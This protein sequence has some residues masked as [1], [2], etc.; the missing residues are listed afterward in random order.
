M[1]IRI[2]DQ[3]RIR[4]APEIRAGFDDNLAY[5]AVSPNKRDFS[6]MTAD[7]LF[8]FGLEYKRLKGKYMNPNAEMKTLIRSFLSR[9]HVSRIEK[10]S[11]IAIPLKIREELWLIQGEVLEARVVGQRMIISQG[12]Q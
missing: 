2:E 10:D 6:I 8:S 5:F 7:Y 9:V 11:R 4:I 1:K 12:A 3:Y